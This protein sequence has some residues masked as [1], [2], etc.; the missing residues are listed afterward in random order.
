MQIE[1]FRMVF[2]LVLHN[3]DVPELFSNA[4]CSLVISLSLFNNLQVLVRF[5]FL[6][7]DD[8]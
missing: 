3:S 2:N 8:G 4:G 7:P 1:F 5:P 6:C